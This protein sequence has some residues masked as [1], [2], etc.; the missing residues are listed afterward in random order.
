M[1][2]EIHSTYYAMGKLADDK[3]MILSYFSHKTDIDISCKVSPKEIIC[4]KCR[5]LF[6]AKKQDEYLNILSAELLPQHAKR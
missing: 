1:D 4:M 5:I 6:S 2:N 3:L